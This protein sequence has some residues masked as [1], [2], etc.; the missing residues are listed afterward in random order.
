MAW[1]LLAS[2]EGD[3]AFNMAMDEALLQSMQPAQVARS[4]FLCLDRKSR[5]VRISKNIPR[6]NA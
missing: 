1:L 4:S 6:S 5:L 3:P 2:G